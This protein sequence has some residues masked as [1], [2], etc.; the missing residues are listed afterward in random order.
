MKAIIKLIEKYNPIGISIDASLIINNKTG[1]RNCEIE[2]NKM[3]RSKYAGCYPTNLNLYPNSFSV[4]L[5]ENLKSMHY[6]MYPNSK[7]IIECY[8]HAS[9]IELFNLNKRLLYKKGSITTKK[10]GQ[11]LL[12]KLIKELST[13][14]ILKLNIK[15]QLKTTILNS[16]YIKQLKGQQ[17]KDN[18][19]ALDSIIC[20]YTCA[21]LANNQSGI[22]FGNKNSGLVWVP[23]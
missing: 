6:K 13:N 17:L 19:D 18:E 16:N 7:W 8:P 9:I 20:L 2:L 11:I 15:P 23:K 1:F 5:Y 14:P 4:Q 21:L 3:Y 12:A 10:E 22:F